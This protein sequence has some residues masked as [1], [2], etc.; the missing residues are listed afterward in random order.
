VSLLRRRPRCQ[1][2]L[3]ATTGRGAGTRVD[4]I[5]PRDGY[6]PPGFRFEDATYSRGVISTPDW[7]A[8]QVQKLA[9]TE[10]LKYQLRAN[11]KIPGRLWRAFKN[12][13]RAVTRIVGK[14]FTRVLESYKNRPI[15]FPQK[16]LTSEST[17]S[18]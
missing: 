1:D 15:A 16:A 2:R 9:N 7:T 3:H 18:V 6:L 8:E 10:L 12:D 5:S 4:D 17:T 13:P 14:V 11:L